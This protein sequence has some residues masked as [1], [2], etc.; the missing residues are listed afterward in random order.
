MPNLSLHGDGLG[1]VMLTAAMG[2]S[3]FL[4]GKT[5]E[6]HRRQL[7]FHP[8]SETASPSRGAFCYFLTEYKGSLRVV[9]LTFTVTVLGG[10]TTSLTLTFTIL[11][12]VGCCSILL[13]VTVI[14]PALSIPVL[15]DTATFFVM[16]DPHLSVYEYALLA[17]DP[18]ASCRRSRP[19]RP[20]SSV[21]SMRALAPTGRLWSMMW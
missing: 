8:P 7:R 15:V 10:L 4:P 20:A 1:E 21:P 19:C 5:C 6:T 9:E 18:E 13:T 2:C 14:V 17:G 11:G 3:F 16:L 12:G